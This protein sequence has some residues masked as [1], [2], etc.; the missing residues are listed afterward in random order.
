[1]PTLG[2]LLAFSLTARCV[3]EVVAVAIAT[4][5][6]EL[7]ALPLAVVVE[8]AL[9]MSL[10]RSCLLG[11]GAYVYFHPRLCHLFCKHASGW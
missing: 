4:T 7:F 2:F 1:M 9:Q 11:K 6:N 5:V 8:V 10:A 3:W